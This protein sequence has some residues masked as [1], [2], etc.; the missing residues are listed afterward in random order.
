MTLQDLINDINAKYAN[1]LTVDQ[2][3]SWLNTI[4]VPK[5]ILPAIS[6]TEILNFVT[7]LGTSVYRDTAGLDFQL[8]D[9][10]TLNSNRIMPATKDDDQSYNNGYW[11]IK[12]LND[13]L[14]INPELISASDL[15]IYVHYFKKRPK[16]TT[17]Q[18]N[19]ELLLSD[20]YIELLKLGVLIFMAKSS[21]DV[22]QANN[23]S[24]DYNDLLGR[25]RANKNI[26][27][28]TDNQIKDVMGW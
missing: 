8:I 7:I 18:L 26:S 25:L 20:E 4:Q 15:N 24:A 28:D 13:Y 9:R 3:I 5:E 12:F 1:S 6:N 17:V 2:Q 19:M 22:A 14:F 16:Y 21:G 11:Y 10:I 23:F 27:N